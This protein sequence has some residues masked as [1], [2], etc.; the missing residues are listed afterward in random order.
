[1]SNNAIINKT[2]I[3]QLANEVGAENIPMLLDIFIQ[4]LNEYSEKI[5]STLDNSQR[6]IE[7][8]EICHALKSNAASFGAVELCNLAKSLDKEFKQGAVVSDDEKF[9][10]LNELIK[11]T[12][13]HYCE[14]VAGLS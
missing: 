13:S 14:F 9:N 11:E 7:C 6:Q 12:K 10:R 4:E 8:A 2:H 1:M 5:Q 3:E